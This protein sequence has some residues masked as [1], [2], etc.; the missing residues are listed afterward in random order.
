MGITFFEHTK[1]TDCW[2]FFATKADVTI[3]LFH[4][5]SE[6]NCQGAVKDY[7]LADAQSDNLGGYA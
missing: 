1:T 7:K 5:A 3:V 6:N 2:Q 4:F